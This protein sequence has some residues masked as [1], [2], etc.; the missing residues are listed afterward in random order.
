MIPRAYDPVTLASDLRIM[1]MHHEMRTATRELA[2]LMRKALPEAGLL[3]FCLSDQGD[4]FCLD[5]WAPEGQADPHWREVPFHL[6]GDPDELR[7]VLP[8]HLH[9]EAQLGPT[10]QSSGP[11]PGLWVAD[12][13]RG[14]YWMDLGTVLRSDP[15][16]PA[17]E[18]LA[19]RDPG[20]V[21]DVTLALGG[22][23]IPAGI[24]TEHHVD[25]GAGRGRLGWAEHR[26]HC[27]DAASEAMRPLVRKAFDSPPGV[28]HIAPQ[29]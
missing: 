29:T 19:V 7:Y 15:P 9:A 21:T 27:L 22:E 6:D 17:I 18:I 24:A 3:R 16:G 11:V 25:A 2:A 26:D 20:G 28:E 5:G 12:P 4:W 23:L 14:E 1:L 8:R 10:P 13:E